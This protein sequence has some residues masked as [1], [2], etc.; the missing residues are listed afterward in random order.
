MAVGNRVLRTV[1]RGGL[2]GPH[3]VLIFGDDGGLHAALSPLPW[4]AALG[5]GGDRAGRGGG[6]ASLG[7]AAADV[8]LSAGQRFSL[9][10]GSRVGAPAPS[11]VDAAA[12]P[13]VAES[14]RWI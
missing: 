14:S 6:S 7:S 3:C 10:S 4:A 5:G 2:G 8:Y 12:V 1:E 11:P 13:A 9:A